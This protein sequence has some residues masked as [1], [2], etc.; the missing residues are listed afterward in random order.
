MTM[1]KKKK[2]KHGSASKAPTAPLIKGYLPVRLTLPSTANNYTTHNDN[3]DGRSSKDG[4]VPIDLDDTFF[5]VKEHFGDDKNT[6]FVANIPVVPGVSG[7]IIL[8]SLLGRFGAVERVTVI[9]NPRKQRQEQRSDHGQ[10]LA[11]A[12]SS[13]A[14]PGLTPA[15]QS[16]S[17]SASLRWTDRRDLFPTFHKPIFGK[18]K[19]AHVVFSSSS[20]MK[21]AVQGLHETMAKTPRNGDLPG[22][23][24][25]RLELQTLVDRTSREAKQEA[26]A[27]EQDVHGDEASDHSSD[28]D[29]DMDDTS[30]NRPL[31]GI[32]AIAERYRSSCQGLSRDKLLLECN[33]V[34]EEFEDAEEADRLAREAAK[35]QPDDDGFVTVSYSK[36]SVGSKRELEQGVTTTNRRKGSKRHRKKK[37]VNGTSELK[38]FYRFQMKETR[39]K[40]LQELRKRFEEDLARVKKLKEE[41]QY[42]PF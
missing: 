36:Q 21:S 41:K 19:F 7:K 2:S 11:T 16:A 9:E 3:D 22:L 12:F 15:I 17:Q 37:D 25:K 28:D 31:T 18:E 6:L 27:H 14:S 38:D 32:Q 5:F 23:V 1:T 39:R 24:L 8:R 33:R 30:T 20:D 10:R 40:N 42:R 13:S 35:N 4:D 34:M 26:A 29:S